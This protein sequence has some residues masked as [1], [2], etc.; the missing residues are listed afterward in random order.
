MHNEECTMRG[1]F[2]KNAF[3]NSAWCI[4][5][6]AFLPA[7]LLAGAC[8]S[9]GG[10]TAA[11][12]STSSSPAATPPDRQTLRPISLPDLSGLEP[13]VARQLRGQYA[14]L[15]ATLQ[16]SSTTDV[17]LGAAY[18]EMGKLLL[19]AEYRD[20]A[21]PCFLNAQTLVPTDARWPYYLA[22][23][24]K[25][26]GDAPKAVRSFERA[27]QLQPDDLATLVWL[28]SAYL[29][30]GRPADAEPLFARALSLQPRSVP[31]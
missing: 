18:G 19:A 14:S 20:V 24:Y 16:K 10:T 2:W 25:Q 4:V 21:E 7:A 15:T 28:G 22:H 6:C 5:H 23:L 29:D 27:L 8:G 31:A 30:Q 1:A 26:V 3:W 9:N 17:D 12:A 13:S 11:T